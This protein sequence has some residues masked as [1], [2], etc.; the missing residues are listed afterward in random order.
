MVASREPLRAWVPSESCRRLGATRAVAIV[1]VAMSLWVRGIDRTEIPA[2]G[3]EPKAEPTFDGRSLE[4]WKRLSVNDLSKATRIKAMQA[5]AAFGQAG[6]KDE[7]VAAIKAALEQPQ[8]DEIKRAGYNALVKLGPTADSLLLDGLKSQNVQNRRIAAKELAMYSP[9]KDASKRVVPEKIVVALIQATEDADPTVRAE[10]CVSLG[11]LVGRG[12]GDKCVDRIIPAMLKLLQDEAVTEGIVLHYQKPSVQL[13][14]CH[15]LGM[16]H[17][18]AEAAIPALVALLERKPI[19]KPF[20][21]LAAIQALG[22]IGPP[23]KAAIP[24][25]ERFRYMGNNVVDEAIQKIDGKYRDPFRG[26]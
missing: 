12:A 10:A 8:E 6:H 19:Q 7:A 26:R 5:F 15:A 25:L 22:L 4:E 23:A 13:V 16:C 2:R 9:S 11:T 14:A 17:A 1:A 20:D 24:V 18:K 21:K 3:G